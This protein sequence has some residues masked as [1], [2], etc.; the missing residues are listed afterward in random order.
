MVHIALLEVLVLEVEVVS[1]FVHF[2]DFAES[3]HVELSD[4]RFDLVV[5]E[6]ERQDYL[7]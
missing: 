1:F 5:S 2:V 7:L 6:E 4:E 3:I